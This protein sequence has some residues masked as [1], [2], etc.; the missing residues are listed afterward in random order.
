LI[1]DG[2]L[3]ADSD[4]DGRV[5]EDEALKAGVLLFKGVHGISGPFELT[6]DMFEEMDTDADRVVSENEHMQWIH[7]ELKHEM[8]AVEKGAHTEL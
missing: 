3:K 1:L 2:F 5:S 7:E 6:A 4:K 8:A